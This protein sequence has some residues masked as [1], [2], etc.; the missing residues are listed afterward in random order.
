MRAGDLKSTGNMRITFATYL[1]FYTPCLSDS[2]IRLCLSL[3]DFY[4]EDF[5]ALAL[6][7][8]RRPGIYEDAKTIRQIVRAFY[9]QKAEETA[10]EKTRREIRN[11]YR[12]EKILKGLSGVEQKTIQKVRAKF[13][14]QFL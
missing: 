2:D 13:Q 8:E 5:K 14:G 4:K 9:G 6:D 1:N 7:I 12:E 3:F 10:A 11:F